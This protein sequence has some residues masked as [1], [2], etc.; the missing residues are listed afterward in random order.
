MSKTLIKSNSHL[1][2]DEKRKLSLEKNISTS[3]AIEGIFIVREE[4]S[5]RFVKKDSNS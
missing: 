5:G 2:N 1:Q 3:S 4:Q